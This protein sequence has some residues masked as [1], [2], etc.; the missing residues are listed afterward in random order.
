MAIVPQLI[1]F[2]IVVLIIITVFMNAYVH[3]FFSNDTSSITSA[4]NVSPISNP[5]FQDLAFI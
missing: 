3:L 1:L 4:G 2:A 5:D